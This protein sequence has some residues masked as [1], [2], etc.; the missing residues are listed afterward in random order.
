MFTTKS[1]SEKTFFLRKSV[2]SSQK[3]F[4]DTIL[5]TRSWLSVPSTAT[6]RF[7]PPT[8][9][10]FHLLLSLPAFSRFFTTCTSSNQ[11]LVLVSSIPGGYPR[12]VPPWSLGCPI[13]S[14]LNK[15]QWKLHLPF[16]ALTWYFPLVFHIWKSE[17]SCV[18][19][20]GSSLASND[21]LI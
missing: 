15:N 18:F 20:W 8:P 6:K 12:N 13:L 2:I 10:G 17:A 5:G 3:T 14:C 19:W 1:F 21:I 16:I 4:Y 11:R 7:P 9:P